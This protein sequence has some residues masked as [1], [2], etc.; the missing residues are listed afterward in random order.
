MNYYIENG[1]IKLNRYKVT[2]T[3]EIKNFK[4]NKITNTEVFAS[5]ENELNFIKQDLDVR[6][7][8]YD[9]ENIDVS[10]YEEFEG[11]AARTIDE[12]HKIV[13]PSIDEIKRKKIE[14][15]KN[16]CRNTIYKGV[17][18]ELNGSIKHFSLTMEDQININALKS[19]IET[20]ILDISKGV[21]YH[22]DGEL[23]TLFPLDEFNK[24]YK[25]AN[26][27][28]IEQTSYCNHLIAYI[29]EVE[30]KS[31]IYKVKYGMKLSESLIK[32]MNNIL[33]EEVIS[34]Q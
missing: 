5:D 11:V 15:I 31:D 12:A 28:I 26:Y 16:E 4:S 20:D 18:V 32:N 9:I 19:Q 1:K 23:C 14:E 2:Y 3:E 22:A 7:I 29:K 8:E 25:E 6:Q 10:D 30:E 33:G 17:D 24:I 13:N 27:F 34:I 21:P